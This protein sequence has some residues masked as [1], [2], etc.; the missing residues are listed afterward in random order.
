M[1]IIECKRVLF[2]DA[3]A[4]LL[5]LKGCEVENGEGAVFRFTKQVLKALSDKARDQSVGRAVHWA[6]VAKLE[7]LCSESMFLWDEKPRNGSVDIERYT[8]HGAAFRFEGVEYVAKITSKVY[9]GDAAHVAY[10][11][12]ALTIEKNDARG[13]ADSILARG[14]GLDPSVG[15]RIQY[16]LNAVK[17]VSTGSISEGVNK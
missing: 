5:A 16:F 14:Q 8:K 7:D 10:S 9:P 17:G 6:A 15:S 3:K 12:E 2:Q 1:K 11:V 4:H 13:I